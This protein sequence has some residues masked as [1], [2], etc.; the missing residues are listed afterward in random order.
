MAKSWRYKAPRRLNVGAIRQEV[1]NFMNQAADEMKKDFIATQ[2]TWNHEVVFTPEVDG[3][4]D[5]AGIFSVHVYTEDEQYKLVDAGAPPHAIYPV[6]AKALRFPGTFSPKTVPGVLK[7]GPGF[8]G[9]PMQIR[10]SVWHPGFEARNFDETVAASFKPKF[11][12]NAEK[13]MSAIRKA[14]N[15]AL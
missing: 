8:S 3:P 14:S 15:N 10:D 12:K 1:I 9:P 11:E 4:N 2:D 7:A 6:K 13:L 5:L